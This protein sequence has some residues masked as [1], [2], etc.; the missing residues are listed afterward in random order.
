MIFC[1]LNM[2]KDSKFLIRASITALLFTLLYTY[3]VCHSISRIYEHDE[4]IST[5]NTMPLTKQ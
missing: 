4:R 2:D 5:A 3:G 1:I